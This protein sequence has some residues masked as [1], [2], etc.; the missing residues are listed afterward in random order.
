MKNLCRAGL[1]L[2]VFSSVL[3]LSSCKGGIN[4]NPHLESVFPEESFFVFTLDTRDKVQIDNLMSLV[5]L[6][7]NDNEESLVFVDY[8]SWYFSMYFVNAGVGDISFDE[9]LKAVFEEPFKLGFAMS[10]KLDSNKFTENTV[11]AFNQSDRPIEIDAS[12]GGRSFYDPGLSEIEISFDF[13]VNRY[14][15]SGWSD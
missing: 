8:L 5:S 9:N 12:L 14:S 3:I 7:K 4:E 2:A 11:H 15:M 13:L 10:D 6:F 1:F